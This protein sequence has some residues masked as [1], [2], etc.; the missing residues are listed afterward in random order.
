MKQKNSLKLIGK[1]TLSAI[2]TKTKE[3]IEKRGYNLICTTGKGLVGDMLIDASGFDTGLTY[4]AIGTSNTAVAVGNTQ[5]TAEATRKAITSRTRAVSDI[6]LSTFFTAAESTYNIKEAGVFGHS[7]ASL[8]A[9]SG[10]LFSHWLVSF[11]NSA[12]LYDLSWEYV[13]TIA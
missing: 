7:T 1:W 8:T 13:L 6:T 9:N 2:N 12:G 3:V 11:D 5:L 10:V 4:H